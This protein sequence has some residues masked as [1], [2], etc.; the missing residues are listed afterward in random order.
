MQLDGQYRRLLSPRNLCVMISWRLLMMIL[1]WACLHWTG[2]TLRVGPGQKLFLFTVIG[3]IC[4]D[5]MHGSP[6]HRS[7]P[8]AQWLQLLI[9]ETMVPVADM[10]FEPASTPSG[11]SCAL[12]S[13]E[14]PLEPSSSVWKN[15][16]T[17]PWS[18]PCIC[19][20]YP[21]CCASNCIEKHECIIC[22]QAWLAYTFMSGYV[23]GPVGSCP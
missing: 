4:R 15:S 2:S 11:S 9:L 22:V 16:L 5:A 18:G 17:V 3:W 6:A 13:S 10:G 20:R 1:I 12:K 21:L 23:V 8:A 19:F 7:V 14:L